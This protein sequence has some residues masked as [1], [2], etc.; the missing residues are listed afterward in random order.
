M[1]KEKRKIGQSAEASQ[2]QQIKESSSKLFGMQEMVVGKPLLE[3]CTEEGRIQPKRE[4]DDDPVTITV[5]VPLLFNVAALAGGA[6]CILTLILAV[7]LKQ[8]PLWPLKN[9]SQYAAKVSP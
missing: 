9:I 8:L 7:Y 1:I 6:G 5:K 2:R 4:E 3:H